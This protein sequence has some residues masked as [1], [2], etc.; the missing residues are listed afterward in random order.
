MDNNSRAA[1]WIS[2]TDHQIVKERR[3]YGTM[4]SMEQTQQ[5]HHGFSAFSFLKSLV[6]ITAAAVIRSKALIG[7]ASSGKMQ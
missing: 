5:H 6:G 3:F 4:I 2:G 7:Q 1:S